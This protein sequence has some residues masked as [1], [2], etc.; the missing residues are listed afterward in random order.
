MKYSASNA[1]SRA[2]LIGE[3][4]A[5]LEKAG[6]AKL[7]DETRRTRHGRTFQIEDRYVRSIDEKRRV[8][9]Y[10]SIANN[11]IRKKGADAI[12]I[13]SQLSIEGDFD[14]VVCLSKESRVNR[15]G[16]VKAIA[17]RMIDRMRNVWG[18]TIKLGSCPHCNTTMAL[19]KQGK[20]FC[21]IRCWLRKE[22]QMPNIGQMIVSEWGDDRPAEYAIIQGVRI[23]KDFTNYDIRTFKV[24]EQIQTSWYSLAT[25]HRMRRI[26]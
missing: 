4:R 7:P 26:V 18:E 16:K 19:S 21:A 13:L 9:V 23:S 6:F 12:R 24:R 17:G 11:D 22:V 2:A 10:T 20:A 15:V 14:R 3:M 8:I 1:M 25:L 5:V